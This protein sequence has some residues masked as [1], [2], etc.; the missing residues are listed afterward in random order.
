MKL[1]DGDAF[2]EVERERLAV[3]HEPL[4]PVV[5]LTVICVPAIYSG[6]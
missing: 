2:F 3:E 4:A 1:R 6:L 5:V